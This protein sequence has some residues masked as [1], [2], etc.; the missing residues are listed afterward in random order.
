MEISGVTTNR[1]LLGLKKSTATRQ[2]KPYHPLIHKAT[3]P[4]VY[5]KM[6]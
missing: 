1:I 4:K 2:L 5:P 3:K 6:M